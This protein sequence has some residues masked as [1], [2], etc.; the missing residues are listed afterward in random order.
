MTDVRPVAIHGVPRSGT[1]WLGEIVNSSPQ[2][3]YRFQPLFSYAFKGRITRDSEPER[4]RQ[5]FADILESDDDFLLQTEARN[6]GRLPYFVKDASPSVVAYKEVRYHDILPNLLRMCTPLRV[7]VIVRDP[8]ATIASWL[9]A[10]REFRADLGWSRLDEWRYAIKKNLNR[11]EEYNGFERW[12]E[13]TSMFLYLASAF[14]DRVK[15]VRYDQLLE[16]PCEITKELLD[17]IGVPW[18][19]QTRQFLKESSSIA[20]KDSY[21]VFRCN[22]TDD[23]WKSSLETEIV[24]AICNDLEGSEL[25]KFLPKR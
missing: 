17:F 19:E 25:Q 14:S 5:F 15:L 7:V 12:K 23:S 22:H 1:S 24:E 2:V 16:S 10:P 6:T 18:C 4:I 9:N 11:P 8:L 20:S 3:A 21:S 13:A